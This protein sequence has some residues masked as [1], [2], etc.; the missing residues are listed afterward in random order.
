MEHV[1]R[2]VLLTAIYVQHVNITIR[3]NYNNT[4]KQRHN[5]DIRK[6]YTY[7]LL[8]HI[9]TKNSQ[10]HCRFHVCVYVLVCL[11]FYLFKSLIFSAIFRIFSALCA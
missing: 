2:K 8:Y 4:K 1:T 10:S 9:I 7:I 5:K 6:S 3:Y 11:L